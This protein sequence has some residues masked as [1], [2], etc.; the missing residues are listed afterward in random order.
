MPCPP[1]LLK[2]SVFLLNTT[3]FN[4]CYSELTAYT[5]LA[6]SFIWLVSTKHF[7]SKAKP[8]TDNDCSCHVK[9]VALANQSY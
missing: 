7:N 5:V 3:A 1:F 8:T 6:Y 2:H 9:A 4:D